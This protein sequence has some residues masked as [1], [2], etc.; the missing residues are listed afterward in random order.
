MSLFWIALL[1]IML[2]P[3]AGME[4]PFQIMAFALAMVAGS[5][6]GIYIGDVLWDLTH[7]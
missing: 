5:R 3:V 2:A 4:G 1:A 7:R 6:L